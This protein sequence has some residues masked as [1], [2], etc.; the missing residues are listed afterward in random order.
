MSEFEQTEEPRRLAEID[1]NEVSLV[2][3]PA[4]RRKF[5]IVKRLED[6][7]PREE[8]DLDEK[9]VEEEEAQSEEQAAS[10]VDADAA[11]EKSE[12]ETV[13]QD[14]S[15]EKAEDEEDEE[16]EEE[17]EKAD[18]AKV[19]EA[20]SALI[21]WL[22]EQAQSAEGELK[23]QLSAFLDALGKDAEKMEGEEEEEEEDTEKS[24]SGSEGGWQQQLADVNASLQADVAK[25]EGE[26]EDEED[27][28]KSEEAAP[29]ADYVTAEQF[30]EFATGITSVLQQLAETQ[31]KVS[32]SVSDLSSFT[33]V[34]KAADDVAEQDEV[35]KAANSDE[36]LFAGLIK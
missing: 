33:P 4:I 3:S 15:Q 30:N 18:P 14:A 2:D 23:G 12:E 6:G 36:K 31:T 27:T 26:E 5:L 24:E 8:I 21:P 19:M 16:E 17:A 29:A 34:S 1:A 10:D 7:M 11:P 28:E 13:A 22:M 32:K 9:K 25:A 20:A 35:S